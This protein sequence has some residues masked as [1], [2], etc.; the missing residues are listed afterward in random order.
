MINSPD[1]LA[2]SSQD[3]PVVKSPPTTPLSPANNAPAAS[4]TVQLKTLTFNERKEIF[5]K[6]HLLYSSSAKGRPPP[7]PTS[8]LN[9]PPTTT[10]KPPL[11]PPSQKDNI[12]SSPPGLLQSQSKRQRIDE[13]S[14]K[15]MECA[16][17]STGKVSESDQEQEDINREKA[18]ER[19]QQITKI[20][21]KI[22]DEPAAKSKL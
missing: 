16:K 12:S 17:E 11:Q 1:A 3:P 8:E 6:Q 2:K 15:A 14:V 7:I 20:N 18:S 22:L 21:L 5:N 9:T 13:S 19:R 4:H 10:T